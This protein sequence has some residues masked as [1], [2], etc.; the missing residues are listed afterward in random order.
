MTHYK[1]IYP[2]TKKS[3]SSLEVLE[4]SEARNNQDVEDELKTV[5]L[6]RRRKPIQKIAQNQSNGIRNG[7]KTEA[8]TQKI[9][10]KIFD[11]NFSKFSGKKL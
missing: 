7:N 2:Q 1:F 10:V 8:S 4:C 9:Q 6:P 11:A 3:T 5:T